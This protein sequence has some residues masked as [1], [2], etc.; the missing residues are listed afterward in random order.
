MFLDPSIPYLLTIVSGVVAIFQLKDS[1]VALSLT[2]LFLWLILSLTA[3]TFQALWNSDEL[4]Q[5]GPFVEPKARQ[6]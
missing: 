1:K 2:T 6:G 3:V 5:V 4:Y